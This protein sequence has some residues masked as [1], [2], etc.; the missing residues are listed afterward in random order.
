M[1]NELMII[2]EVSILW[3]IIC[4]LFFLLG[5]VINI[6]FT[7]A[8]FYAF[9]HVRAIKIRQDPKHEHPR[10]ASMRKR[11]LVADVAVNRRAF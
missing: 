1:Y 11:E 8:S 2:L 10:L 4:V 7:A 6:L 5:F 9:T 3:N